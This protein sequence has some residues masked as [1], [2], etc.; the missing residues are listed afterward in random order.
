MTEGTWHTGCTRNTQMCSRRSGVSLRRASLAFTGEFLP[1]SNMHPHKVG[2][3]T[4]CCLPSRLYQLSKGGKLCVPAM[5]VNDSVTKQKFDN[6]YCC[7]ESILDGWVA[8]KLWS[9][10]TGHGLCRWAGCGLAQRPWRREPPL[11]VL[12]CKSAR[13]LDVE[14]IGWGGLRTCFVF[15]HL[16]YYYHSNISNQKLLEFEVFHLI[17]IFLSLSSNV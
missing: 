14:Q 11:L 16:G 2:A 5:N 1:D 7:R 3:S 8:S 13:S 15:H 17:R 6:L 9:P 12:C 4:S 10:K